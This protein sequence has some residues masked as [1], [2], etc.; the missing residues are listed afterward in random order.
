MKAVIL[1]KTGDLKNLNENINLVNYSLPELNKD[2]A[3]VKI[4]FS[5]INHRDIWITQGLYGGIKLN[6]ILGSDC[7]GIIVKPSKNSLNFEI[8]EEVIINPSLNWGVNNSHQIEKGY[9]ILGMPDNGTFAEFVIINEKNI[10]RKPDYLSFEEA[11][12]LPLAGMTAFRASMIKPIINSKTNVVITGIG[13]GVASMCLMFLKTKTDNIFVTSGD[14]SKIE[15]AIAIGAKGGVNYKNS[16]WI[17]NLLDLTSGNINVIIDGTGGDVL[18]SLIDKISY[19]GQIV[20]YGATLGAINNFNMNKF[21]WKQLTFMGS[22]MSSDKEFKDMLDY[23]KY[24]KL[25][26]VIDSVFNLNDY[27]NAFNKMAEGK[28]FGKIVMKND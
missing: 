4:K 26:P 23:C 15:K 11:S 5:S 7:S 18:N 27:L 10:Y 25:K 8:G 1:K 14:D 24:Y 12:A 3:I 13:G 2:E 6:C 28:Q 20:S 21:F 9:K 22:T 17:N 19:G 16:D